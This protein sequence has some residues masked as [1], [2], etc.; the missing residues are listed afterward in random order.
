LRCPKYAPTKFKGNEIP[1]HITTNAKKVPKGMALEEFCDH[2][3][4]FNKN[5]IVMRNPGTR[6]AVIMAFLVHEV[7]LKTLYRRAE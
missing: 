4:R 5:T 2:T 3:K 7:P 6:V 1:N